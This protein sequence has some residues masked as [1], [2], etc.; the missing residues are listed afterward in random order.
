MKPLFLFEFLRKANHPF[1]RPVQNP[2][3]VGMVQH[4]QKEQD[5][6]PA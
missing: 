2:V 4:L 6:L 1:H 3:P 5:H